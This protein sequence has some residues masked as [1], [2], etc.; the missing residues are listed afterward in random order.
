MMWITDGP[1]AHAVAK[2]DE[3]DKNRSEERLPIVAVFLIAHVSA[4]GIPP[5]LEYAAIGRG[6]AHRALC[7]AHFSDTILF[8]IE[9]ENRG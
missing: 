7:F 2:I 4:S 6:S 3:A 9:T 1:A 5:G 8:L